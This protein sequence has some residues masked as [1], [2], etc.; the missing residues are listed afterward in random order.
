M[1]VDAPR[2]KCQRLPSR[3]IVHTYL[4]TVP[5]SVLPSSSAHGRHGNE[6]SEEAGE[7]EDERFG[8]ELF[9]SSA[10]ADFGKDCLGGAPSS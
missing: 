5:Y 4:G 8:L 6:T 10:D 3:S 1:T 9:L 2:T 7:E